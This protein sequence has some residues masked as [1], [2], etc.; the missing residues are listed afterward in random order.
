MILVTGSAGFIGSHV[1]LN[2]AKHGNQEIV[3]IDAL[4]PYYSPELKY[5]RLN[6]F[7][8]LPNVVVEKI[9]LNSL[10]LD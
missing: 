4:T 1:L 9:D 3:G 7:K 8:N 10:K 6:Y 2:L 5:Y